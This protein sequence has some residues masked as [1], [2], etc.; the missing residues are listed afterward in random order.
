M[1]QH[2]LS[3]VDKDGS[4]MPRLTTGDPWAP[5]VTVTIGGRDG[6]LLRAE[7]DL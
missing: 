3:V 5:C 1:G 6:E 4:I 7:H 2:E